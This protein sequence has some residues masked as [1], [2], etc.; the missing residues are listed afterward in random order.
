MEQIETQAS[1]LRYLTQA[2]PVAVAP[3]SDSASYDAQQA[4][5]S[6]GYGENSAAS[7]LKRGPETAGGQKQT[8][9]KRNRYISIACNECKRRKIKCNGQT[10]CQRCGNLNLACLYAPNC[11]ANSFRDSDEFKQITTKLSCLQQEVDWLNQVVR[12]LQTDDS[13][14]LASANRPMPDAPSA[15]AQPPSQ[16][17][18]PSLNSPS[19]FRAL[20]N[21]P[22][23]LN[24]SNSAWPG[25]EYRDSHSHDAPD[26]LFEFG[27][28]E[29]LRLF[30]LH[31]DE[32]AIMYPVLATHSLVPYASNLASQLHSAKTQQ[33]LALV[34]NNDKTLQLKMIMCCSLALESR[35]H[36][37]RADR[38]YQ[39]IEAHVNRKL[40]VDAAD[41]ANLPLLCT[42]AVY[43]FLSND[44]SLAW[45][46]MGHVMRLCFELELHL[47][48]G[49][50]SIS[51]QEERTRTLNNFWSAYVLD[52]MFSFATNLPF[53]VS[54]DQ[55]DP[56]LPLPDEHP[57]LV[58]MISCSRIA[59]K[60][61]RPIS[62][63]EPII[64]H[65]FGQEETDVLN[66]EIYNWY[67]DIPNE[68]KLRDWSQLDSTTI[69]SGRLQRLKI[70]TYLKYN[71]IR[72]WLYAPVFHN[73]TTILTN[74]DQ[75]Q[76]A[77]DV[78]KDTIHFLNHVSKTTGRYRTTQ[79][80]Y[81]H[82]VTCAIAIFFLASIHAPVR[83]STMCRDDFYLAL[84]LM[85]DLPER[86]WVSRRLWRSIKSLQDNIVPSLGLSVDAHSSAALG[87]VGLSRGQ[88]E[89]SPV[90]LSPFASPAAMATSHQSFQA[91]SINGRKMQSEMT[92]IFEGL[93]SSNEFQMGSSDLDVAANTEF[94]GSSTGEAEF[95]FDGTAFE[96]FR[97]FF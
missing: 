89:P 81:H 35:G 7:S 25:S 63:S 85:K 96:F 40:M 67:Q 92:R 95:A 9:S 88:M 73:T 59:A 97:D 22:Y 45:R 87:M 58:A 14:R 38:L 8:R 12:A 18:E 37:R 5:G 74:L 21:P 84:D 57:Y 23:S 10:P 86:S 41:V 61:W 68:I 76:R 19:S 2:A 34:L 82:F 29:I 51:S 48:R 46:V 80:C 72:I 36:S 75:A 6:A 32:L 52:H 64:L 30:R 49:L 33:R 26:A 90:A 42:L 91:S 31:E 1:D 69:S 20:T 4:P 3:L 16:S 70:M 24:P 71:Q 11:C 54:H 60:I 66:R 13:L 93:I 94:N 62:N 47:K 43:R 79:S 39:S 53:A 55:I 65:G 15:L 77:V 44:E 83:F 78:A 17:P 50:M 28:D 56:Q 27:K